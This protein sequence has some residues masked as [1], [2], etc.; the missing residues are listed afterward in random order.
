MM[1][2]HMPAARA[3]LVLL[4]LVIPG[5]VAAQIDYRNLDD[6]RPV[7]TEDAY[8]VERYAFELIVP[9]HFEAEAG[10]ESVHV[11]VPELAYGV[12]ANAQ[13]GIKLPIA[14]V[15]AGGETETGLSGI[16][17]F[18]LY[19]LNTEARWLPALAVRGDLSLPAGGLAGDATR[20]TVKAIATRS[21]GAT[22]AHLNAAWSF[23]DDG[24]LAVAEP[25]VRW[26]T[27]VA[28]DR[29]LIRRSLLFI[30]EVS[31]SEAVRGAPAEVN[32][33]AGFRW[34]WTPT[35]VLDAGVQRR[36]RDDIGPDIGITIGLS[37]A[38]ALRGLMPRGGR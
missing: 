38:F 20:F 27:S 9:Y 11:T 17:L 21:W 14:A 16:H 15:S 8:P 32:A 25:A 18:G 35:F 10:G 24:P 28:V 7:V 13:V 5:S 19:N 2:T 22:R 3:G 31:A 36:L 6:D 26:R 37:H 23:G 1:H 12:L 33:G 29:A 34:Q 30:A 4:G